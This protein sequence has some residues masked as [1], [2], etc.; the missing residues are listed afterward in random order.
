[1]VEATDSGERGMN[2]V[3]MTIINPWKEYW[4]SLGSNQLPPVLKY[5]TVPTKLWGSENNNDNNNNMIMI[6]VIIKKKKNR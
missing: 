3:A 6:I 1:M 5:A 4:S 2:P